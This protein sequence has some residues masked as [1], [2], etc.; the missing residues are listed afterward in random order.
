MVMVFIG[1]WDILEMPRVLETYGLI[2][3]HETDEIFD[4]LCTVSAD[5]ADNGDPEAAAILRPVVRRAFQVHYNPSGL[6]N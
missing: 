5:D 2:N 1:L 3:E 6:R 4:R